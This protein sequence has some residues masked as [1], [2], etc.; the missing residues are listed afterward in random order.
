MVN[1]VRCPAPGL[2]GGAAGAPARFEINGAATEPSGQYVLHRGDT[3][4]IETGGGGGMGTV[5]D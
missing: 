2:E 1:R 5:R 3:V 4:L